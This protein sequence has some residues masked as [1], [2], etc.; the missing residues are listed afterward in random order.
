MRSPILST[1]PWFCAVLA[2]ALLCAQTAPQ[3][4]AGPGAGPAGPASASGHA[5]QAAAAAQPAQKAA[6][7]LAAQS[8]TQGPGL[9]VDAAA[10]RHAISPDIYGINGY[11]IAAT[12]MVYDLRLPVT[13][14]GGDAT[15]QFNWQSET[16]NS[17]ADWYFE[18]GMTSIAGK[19][20][21]FEQFHE[22][23]LQGGA[24]SVGTIPIMGWVT[25]AN[26]A[27]PCSFDFQKYPNQMTGTGPAPGGANPPDGSWTDPYHS[28]CGSGVDTSGKNIVNDP[29][30]TDTAVDPS[31]MQQWVAKEV[32][33][34]G[35]AAQGGVAIWEMDNEPVWWSGV[36]RNIHPASSTFQEIAQDGLEYAAAV[37]AAD[38]TAAVSGPITA[39][40]GDLFFSNADFVSG[41]NSRS[42]IAGGEDWKY[43]NNPVDRKANGDIDFAA[44]YLQQFAQYEQAHGQRLLDYFDVHGYMPGTS[45]S[46]DDAASNAK[47][48][49]G[50]RSF[51][52]PNFILYG[53]SMF[54]TADSDEYL[55]N[56]NPEWNKT[57]QCV[58]LIP[59][60]KQWVASNYPGTKMSITE[61]ILGDEDHVNG[62]LAQADLLGVFGREGLDLAT[63][64]GSKTIQPAYPVAFAFKMYRN[65][66]GQGGAFGETSISAVSDNQDQL[67][68][69]AAQR[70]DSALTLM[71]INKTAGELSSNIALNN[72]Q[73]DSTVQLWQYSAANQSAIVRLPDQSTTASGVGA[74]FPAYSA[75]LLIVPEAST[76]K[77]PKPV[78]SAIVNAALG[79]SAGSATAIAPGT[80]VR[81]TG[82]NLGPAG[83]APDPLAG[84]SGLVGTNLSSVRVL[85]N[86]APAPVIGASS[87]SVLAMVPYTAALNSTSNVQVEYLNSR[88]DS[89]QAQIEAA[90]PG[91][92]TADGTGQG[93]ALAFSFDSGLSILALNSSLNPASAG[94]NLLFYITGAGVLNPP[95]VDGRIETAILPQPTQSVSVTIGGQPATVEAASAPGSVSG[96]LLVNVTVPAGVPS[97]N[98][99]IVVT[100]GTASSQSG[101]TLA[102]K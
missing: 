12:S 21:T 83:G 57:P 102:V 56:A 2:A 67:A 4:F 37:K 15:S 91:V 78:I 11:T 18:T 33:T 96:I 36:H 64:W 27:Y 24:K 51:W 38:P 20:V 97:G 94:S 49:E 101:V 25:S 86:G 62:G 46:G 80:L 90:A 82:Q 84:A 35:P 30:D 23:N 99:P 47:R 87:A 73:P 63:L 31:F 93:P 1:R 74:N 17:G 65:Y 32:S 75:T 53:N 39:G 43:W 72:F 89:F 59:R 60:M 61:Y 54:S 85:F 34:Y 50:I 48:L 28:Q 66:D 92:F 16:S 42:P 71:V 6:S 81:I 44:Y 79:N 9:S 45:V 14:W 58:C 55:L 68:I 77:A 19:S 95:A 13:R 76:L 29:T 52:D 88:S 26:P 22:M 69:Y 100:V 8:F 41:W 7:G 40:W 98:A 5:R 3:R 70:S 10:N